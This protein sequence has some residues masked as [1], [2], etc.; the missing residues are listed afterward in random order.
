[1][2]QKL[3]ENLETYFFLFEDCRKIPPP[4][5][6]PESP[7][8]WGNAWETVGLVWLEWPSSHCLWSSPPPRFPWRADSS[9]GG[10]DGLGGS[11]GKPWGSCNH[12]VSPKPSQARRGGQET[13][14]PPQRW[15]WWYPLPSSTRSNPPPRPINHRRK[16][17]LPLSHR[18]NGW[19]C[20]SVWAIIQWAMP[21]K[22]QGWPYRS[23][24]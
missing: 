4:V 3:G 15:G 1:M 17:P 24:N 8:E 19:Q 7:S 5:K 10:G 12:P 6:H 22:R 16:Q 13:A 21:W 11:I 9:G 2:C 14:A 20:L 23:S 18:R